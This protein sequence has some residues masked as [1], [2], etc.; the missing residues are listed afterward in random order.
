[1]LTPEGL[2][3]KGRI[4]RAVL[5]S[6]PWCKAFSAEEKA[7]FLSMTRTMNVVLAEGSARRAGDQHAE[8]VTGVLSSASPDAA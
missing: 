7:A 5:G 2:E 4:E 1:M 6:M 8:E 3:L